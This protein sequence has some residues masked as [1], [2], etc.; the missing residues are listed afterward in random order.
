[1]RR[2][3]IAGFSVVGNNAW[4]FLSYR[5]GGF[6]F[7]YLHS[8]IIS[9][10]DE[11]TLEGRFLMFHYSARFGWNEIIRAHFKRIYPIGVCLEIHLRDGSRIRIYCLTHRQQEELHNE[12]CRRTVLFNE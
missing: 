4:G 5:T 1:M 11:F 3:P 6:Q 12:L 2:L 7:K 10:H 9:R 8:L